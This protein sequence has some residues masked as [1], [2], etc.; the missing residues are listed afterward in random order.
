MSMNSESNIKPDDRTSIQEIESAV[1]ETSNYG[2]DTNFSWWSLFSTSFGLT[3]SWLG[4]SGSF[5]TGLASG[6]AVLI[7]Y[8]LIIG[9]FFSSAVAITLAELL[10]AFCNS[11]GQY[12][13][14]LQL[15]PPRYKIFLAFFTGILSYFG[16]I[17]TAASVTSTLA[18]SIVALY[19]LK[20]PNFTI[21]TWHIFVTYEVI[22]VFVAIFNIYGKTLPFIT[23]S[24]L[25]FSLLAFIVTLITC[26]ACSSGNFN[27]PKFVFSDFTNT[28]GWENSGIAFIVGLISP[29]WSFV[30]LDAAAHMVDEL[31]YRKAKILVPRAI[32]CTVIL[33]FVTA[34]S[35]SIGIFFCTNDSS[36]IVSAAYPR[37]EIFYQATKNVGGA[38]FLECLCVITGILC[39]VAAHTWQ[40]RICWSFA[41]DNGLPFSNILRKVDPNLKTPVNAHLFSCFWIAVIGCIYQGSSTS[42]N[43]IITA[44]ICL[45]LVSYCIPTV[46]L[47]FKGRSNIDHG[48]FW[49][50]KFGLVAN[51]LTICWTLFCL[52]FL[53]FPYQK[54]VTSGN[55]NYVSAVYGVIVFY[56]I[57]YWYI[58]GKK[59]FNA[60][61]CHSEIS[62]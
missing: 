4:V 16:S 40:A 28:T 50:G 57:A 8:G 17:F 5:G 11:G 62:L 35:Y 3:A 46:L 29:I 44:S 36:K 12:Y 33:G 41:R 24:A 58:I 49:A 51:I 60:G 37:L 48:P 53:S 20:N 18:A 34:F 6:G 1:S 25:Y 31:G 13:W 42:F 54:P 14:S 61:A 39:N 52:T 23:G 38:I 19:S 22:N 43:A 7:I 56:L 26:L 9:A 59:T 55:M 21:E 2:F 32:I 30:G 47:L 15:A 45:L 10:S 27:L